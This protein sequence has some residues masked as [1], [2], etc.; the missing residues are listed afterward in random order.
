MKSI[1][2]EIETYQNNVRLAEK[3]IK[4]STTYLKRFVSY[5]SNE[6]KKILSKYT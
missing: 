2:E 3:T 5:L 4:N 1:I 6:M